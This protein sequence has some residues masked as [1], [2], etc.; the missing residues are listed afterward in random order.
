MPL[1]AAVVSV[2]V[3]LPGFMDVGHIYTCAYI[4]PHCGCF[5]ALRNV[6]FSPWHT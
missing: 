2:R 5:R 4:G 1:E 6:R 3:R